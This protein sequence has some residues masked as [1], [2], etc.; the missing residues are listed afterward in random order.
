MSCTELNQR[1]TR[2]A[3]KGIKT[4]L[5]S[6]LGFSSFS[7]IQL[8]ATHGP[9]ILRGQYWRFVT[10]IFGHHDLLH[11]ALNLWCLVTVGP[12]VEKI[13]DRKKM[14]ILYLVAGNEI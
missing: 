7:L 1:K 10:S 11:I 2:K 4:G 12:I 6:F 8:G 3:K 14:I 9:S 5:D 13:F